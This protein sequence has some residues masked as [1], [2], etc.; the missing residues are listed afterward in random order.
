VRTK[1]ARL[2]IT[3]YDGIPEQDAVEAVLRVVKEG[4]LTNAA[5]Y[6]YMT[7]FPHGRIIVE[8]RRSNDQDLF[9]VVPNQIKRRT[10]RSLP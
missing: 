6:P 2:A 4:R 5:C 3:I 1:T 7:A 8:A 9:R 10:T